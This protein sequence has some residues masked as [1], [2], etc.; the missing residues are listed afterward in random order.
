MI[1]ALTEAVTSLDNRTS[2]RKFAD[3]QPVD[4][5]IECGDDSTSMVR[6][7]RT[8]SHGREVVDSH[9]SRLEGTKSN[10]ETDLFLKRSKKK[11]KI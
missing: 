5:V 1:A 9:K 2:V 10:E 11:S 7:A 4:N 8:V 6:G 3:T